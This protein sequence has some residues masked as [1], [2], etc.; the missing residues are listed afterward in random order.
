MIFEH[1]CNYKT[2]LPSSRALNFYELLEIQ[3]SVTQFGARLGYSA[4]LTSGQDFPDVLS[5][6]AIYA[7]AR[8]NERIRGARNEENDSLMYTKVCYSQMEGLFERF[9]RVAVSLNLILTSVLRESRTQCFLV[10]LFRQLHTGRWPSF[11]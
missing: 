3:K 1:I 11:R 5:R 4:T 9:R 10:D 8:I 6:H 2:S 7:E